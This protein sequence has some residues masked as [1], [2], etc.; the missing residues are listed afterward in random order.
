[1]TGEEAGSCFK[2]IGQGKASLKDI[3]NL[4]EMMGGALQSLG[5]CGKSKR[6]KEASIVESGGDKV[7]T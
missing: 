4:S 6:P 7:E 2:D 3:W 1:M 5:E